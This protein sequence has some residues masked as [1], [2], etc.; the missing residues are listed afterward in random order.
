MIFS[1]SKKFKDNYLKLSE[2]DKAKVKNKLKLMAENPRHPSLRTKRIQGTINIFEAS[3]NKR[4]R[5]TWE[6]EN[7]DKSILLR[8]IGDHDDTLNNP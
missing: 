8:N 3:V 2:N 5:I 6:Y 1:R 7:K 4:I